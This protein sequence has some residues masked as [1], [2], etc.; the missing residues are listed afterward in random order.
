MPK[1]CLSTPREALDYVMTTLAKY[2]ERQTLPVQDAARNGLRRQHSGLY[3]GYLNIPEDRGEKV[4]AISLPEIDAPT[5]PDGDLIRQIAGVVESL[6]M[7]NPCSPVLGLGR[8]T[9]TMVPC[10]GTPLVEELGNTPAYT[11]PLEE[12]LARPVPDPTTSGIMPEMRER[13]AFLK[14]RLPAG[15]GFYI[16]MP[17]MQGP[18]NLAHAVLGEDALMG[19][20][21]KPELYHEFMLRMTDLWIGAWRLLW[22]W[23]GPEWLPP[24]QGN[25]L[26]FA[27]CSVNLV[28]AEFYREF[29]LPY[30]L[31]A[32]HALAVPLYIHPCSGP[33]VFRATL[34]Q[35]P[36]VVEIEA[37]F[38]EKTAAGSISVEEATKLIAN[39][40]ITL[41][42]GQELPFGKEYEFICRDFDRYADNPRL[43]FGY[44]GML[45]RHRD[46]AHI[47]ALHRRLDDYWNSRYGG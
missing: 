34:E 6:R 18:F 5:G 21:V 14:S 19:P 39:R 11:I 7:L 25:R 16:G 38:I 24:G 45:W 26:R 42:I 4:D 22:Q 40:P 3:L 2:P 28:S 10:F 43:T 20:Y 33:H 15:K 32:A 27:E 13:I 9:G 37:G 29:I 17:D 12:A 30:D 1:L 35:L 44:T 31:R 41:H 36:N 46:R 8:G 23:I 47:Q